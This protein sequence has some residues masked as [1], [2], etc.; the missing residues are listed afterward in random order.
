MYKFIEGYRRTDWTCNCAICG[1]KTWASDTQLLGEYT[2]RQGLR[3]CPDCV[4][5]VDYGLVPYKI[6]AERSVPFVNYLIPTPDDS[7]TFSMGTSSE[8]LDPMNAGGDNI[9]TWNNLT[10]Q[11]WALWSGITWS[12]LIQ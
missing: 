8:Y 12:N 4:D 10:K 5:P 7:K 6:P 11:T 3:V 2:G 1:N 9:G